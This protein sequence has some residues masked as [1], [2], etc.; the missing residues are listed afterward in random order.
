[1]P[2]F[3]KLVTKLEAMRYAS[4]SHEEGLNLLA[5]HLHQVDELSCMLRKIGQLGTEAARIRNAL[6]VASRIAQSLLI[7]FGLTPCSST[8]IAVP[9]RGEGNRFAEFGPKGVA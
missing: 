3:Q 5:F 8:R 1:V 9:E 6:N 2:L 7:E 4:S